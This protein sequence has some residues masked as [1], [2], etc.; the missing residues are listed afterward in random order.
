VCGPERQ[1]KT[2][3]GDGLNGVKDRTEGCLE[4]FARCQWKRARLAGRT[5]PQAPPNR[6]EAG[7]SKKN[8]V[9][10]E[11]EV[12]PIMA[13]FSVGFTGARGIDMVMLQCFFRKSTNPFII[14]S[15]GQKL[16]NRRQL[17]GPECPPD[18]G[19]H[20]GSRAGFFIGE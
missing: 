5:N 14:L 6:G 11:G 1:I 10:F 2:I 7:F 19:D 20:Q 4:G 13:A 8:N 18:R 16:C 17:P 12:T 15:R 9:F 3:A